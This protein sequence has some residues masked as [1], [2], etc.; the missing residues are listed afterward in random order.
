M[1][2]TKSYG[3]K[4]SFTVDPSTSMR[5]RSSIV[6]VA[7]ILPS[8]STVVVTS[9]RCGTL[10]TTTGS[11]ASSAPARMGSV[12]FFAPEMRTSPSS[13]TPPWICN[14]SMLALPSLLWRQRLDGQRMDLTPHELPER[15]IDELVPGK[16]ALA[17][18][19]GRNDAR[20]KMGVIVGLHLHLR[21]R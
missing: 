12:A 5:M 1:V 11:R 13:G 14:L 10:A 6:T 17:G 8:S 2:L 4:H 9:L 7:P 21:P 20:R 19:L 16:A 3:A 18:K 15:A